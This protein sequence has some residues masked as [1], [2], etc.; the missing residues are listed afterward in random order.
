MKYFKRTRIKVGEHWSEWQMIDS[1][2]FDKLSDK[3]ESATLIDSSG[4]FID[5]PEN[6]LVQYFKQY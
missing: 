4:A 5:D 1:I 6:P 2:P 3:A